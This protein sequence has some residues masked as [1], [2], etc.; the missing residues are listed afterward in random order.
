[1]SNIVLVLGASGQLGHSIKKITD[2]FKDLTFY[3]AGRDEIDILDPELFSLLDYHCPNIVINCAAYTSVDLAETEILKAQQVNTQA[4]QALSKATANC[5]AALIHLSSDYVYHN[6][7]SGPLLETDECFPKGIYAKSKLEGEKLVIKHLARHIIIR[8]SWLYGEVGNNFVK[9]MLKLAERH[10]SLK[11][12]SDQVGAPTYTHDLALAL[13]QIC[14][15]VC[16]NPFEKS[17]YGIFNYANEGLTSWSEFAKAIFTLKEKQIDIKS[18]STQEYGAAAP[19]P[20]WS[21]LSKNKIKKTFNL[22]IPHWHDALK[23]MLNNLD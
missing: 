6:P 4:L 15:H 17:Y 23:R 21:F 8:T 13:G 19:R 5:G 22:T 7:K 20:K 9:T 14:Q 12:V 16:T 2:R 3:F 11:I 18:I 10:N 1:M